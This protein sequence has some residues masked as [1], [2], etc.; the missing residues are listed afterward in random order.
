[1]N[2]LIIYFSLNQYVYVLIQLYFLLSLNFFFCVFQLT[3]FVAIAVLYR[4]TSET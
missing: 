1:M 3:I 4:Q 2:K